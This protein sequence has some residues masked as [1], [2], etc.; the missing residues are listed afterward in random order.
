MLLMFSALAACSS[1]D[2]E[3]KLKCLT[4][5]FGDRSRYCRAENKITHDIIHFTRKQ[6]HYYDVQT[7]RKLSKDFEQR[8]AQTYH[9][10]SKHTR[11][12]AHADL[13]NEPPDAVGT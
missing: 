8:F 12:L 4:R 13:H 7:M 5:S 6:E 9:Y 3:I 10:L 1:S 2:F 11:T